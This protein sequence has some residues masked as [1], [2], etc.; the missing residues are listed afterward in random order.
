MEALLATCRAGFE[1]DL[2]AELTRRA[3]GLEVAGFCRAK[4]GAGWVAFQAHD[5]A[6]ARRVVEAVPVADLIFARQ[7]I[8]ASG[9]FEGLPAGD[10]VAPLADALAALN[11]PLAELF[12]E[13]P[14]T[15]TGKPLSGLGRK[16]SPPLEAALAGRGLLG[17]PGARHRGHV[18]L[19]DGA[20]AW[21]GLSR[22]A[23]GNPWPMGIPRLRL[24]KLAPSR[25]ARKLEEALLVFLSADQRAR[26]LREGLTAVDLGAAP[27]GWSWVLARR[28]LFVTAVDNARLAEGLT[29]DGQISH[30]RA[31]GFHYRPQRPVDWLVC[32]MVEKPTRI[33]DLVAAWLS[34]GLCRRSIFNLKLPMKKRL[35]EV[36]RCAD[37]LRAAAAGRLRIKHLYHDREEVTACFL[38]GSPA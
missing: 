9:P 27:G 4:P 25:S 8:L 24:P 20:T 2:A 26:W 12:V 11:Q 7:L 16:L 13:H 6:G 29:G 14:D 38:A 33:A 37:T 28:G 17:A 30:L 31:D 35:A 18:L 19:L 22:L 23:D 34:A 10:R 36:D 15:E 1:S 3:E 5:P 21:V 32:D